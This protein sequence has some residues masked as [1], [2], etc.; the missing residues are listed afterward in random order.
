MG[1]WDRAVMHLESAARMCEQSFPKGEV[2]EA[3]AWYVA[4]CDAGVPEA[5]R[6]PEILQLVQNV[7]DVSDENFQIR[8]LWSIRE[9]ADGV[10]L[11][12]QARKKAR[13]VR[14]EDSDQFDAI[15]ATHQAQMKF[16]SERWQQHAKLQLTVPEQD[17]P[18]PPKVPTYSKI[19]EMVDYF[20]NNDER[21]DSL[22]LAVYLKMIQRSLP[23]FAA[24]KNMEIR[25]DAALSIPIKIE[26]LEP[27][28]Q[29][30]EIAPDM[31]VAAV[32]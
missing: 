9:A 20:V 31:A 19:M 17:L 13:Q 23:L 5:L 22:V 25:R 14:S 6:T 7:D 3:V 32:S 15:L 24:G 28:S 26:P 11:L 12:Q 16:M 1:S 27:G 4:V 30:H 29:I 21:Y 2:S 10:A 18:S 8:L